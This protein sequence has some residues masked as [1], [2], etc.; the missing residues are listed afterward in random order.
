[1]R[2]GTSSP[3]MMVK[4]VMTTTTTAVEAT[5]AAPTPRPQPSMRTASGPAKA[6]SPTIPLSMPI[7]V[8]PIWMVDRNVVG[9]STSFNAAIAPRSPVSASAASRARR[10]VASAISDMAN[11]A[12]NEVSKAS[13]RTSIGSPDEGRR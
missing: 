4:K 6:A 5:L 10:L 11:S 3:K 12:L 2:L 9:E 7:E 8:M 13:R 1:M